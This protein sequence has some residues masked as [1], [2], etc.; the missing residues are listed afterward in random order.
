MKNLERA[1]QLYQKEIRLN[2]KWVYSDYTR[3]EK[4]NQFNAFRKSYLHQFC[5]RN[6]CQKLI[7]KI[8][9]IVWSR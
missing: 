7:E 6:I 5:R 8:L 3:N 1:M 4:G 9:R 2:W